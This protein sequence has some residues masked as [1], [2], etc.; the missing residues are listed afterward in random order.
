MSSAHSTALTHRERV[1][2]CLNHQE[3]DRVPRDLMGNATMILDESYLSLIDRLGLAPI[4]PFREG[5]TANFYD[6]RVLERF[7]IDFRR[8]FLPP[9]GRTNAVVP[10]PDG[11]FSDVWGVRYEKNGL[12]VTTLNHPLADAS[13]LQDVEAYP[14]PDGTRLFRTEGLA[15][16]A[17]LMCEETDFAIVARNPFS[18]GFIDRAS[19][20]MGTENFLVGLYTAPEVVQSILGHIL[21]VYMVVYEGFLEEVGRYVQM[22]ETA[23]DI[24]TQSSLLIS[25]E[26]YRRFIKP[27][28]KTFYARIHEL[29]P[30]AFLFRH[31]DGSIHPLID[32]LIE[33]GVDVLNPVQT[34]SAGM[35]AELLKKDFG[36]RLC[37]HGAIERM[38]G[39]PEE[40]EIE[41]ARMMNALKPGGGYIFAPCNHIVDS[42]PEEIIALF[43]A[44]E[45]T[46]G[47]PGR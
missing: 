45:R 14:W 36:D 1:L 18:P 43:D 39:S 9:D 27:L 41:V 25:P 44:A 22:V 37:F 5:T 42:V 15:A 13:T 24:G 10:H 4:P 20:L 21:E 34:S 8:V 26:S 46:G 29:A 31:C 2:L 28:E 38:R 11:T 7:D 6:E 16:K 17:K 47:Y 19:Q 30:D 33:V 3:A 23:D 12:Y 35:D 40:I 32:D